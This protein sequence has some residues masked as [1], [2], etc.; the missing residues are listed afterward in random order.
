MKH[1]TK[2]EI[3]QRLKRDLLDG[4]Q[5]DNLIAKPPKTNNNLG[6]GNTFHTVKM[7][8]TM[9]TNHYKQVERLS[10]VLSN[11]D[12][13]QLCKD[14]H[15]FLYN[16]IQYE[17]DRSLQQLRSPANSWHVARIDGIDCKSYSIFAGCILSCL[18]I[19]YYIRQIKQAKFNPNS[20]THVYIVV[21]A[22]QETANLS[23]GY[24]TIDGTLRTTKECEFTEAKD[25]LMDLKHVGLNA[26]K[27]SRKRKTKKRST[28]RKKTTGLKRPAS[29]NKLLFFQ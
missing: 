9:I 3:S 16:Y 12:L 27:T 19:K 14:I 20:F 5:F 22:N 21:P 28:T 29:S 11:S 10:K 13:S 8:K 2:D 17:A 25:L 6:T 26:P 1:L 15:S 24:F 23:D 4:S 18:G 7:M